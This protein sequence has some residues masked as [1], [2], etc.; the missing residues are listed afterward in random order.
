MRFCTVPWVPN[1]LFL[2]SNRLARNEASLISCKFVINK[3]KLFVMVMLLNLGASFLFLQIKQ[4]LHS[5][6]LNFAKLGDLF[7]VI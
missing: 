1:E 3:G 5:F 4:I 2:A 6:G 7:K